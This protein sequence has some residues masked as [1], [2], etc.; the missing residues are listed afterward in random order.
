MRF[1]SSFGPRGSPGRGRVTSVTTLC[2]LGLG[3]L[4]FPLVGLVAAAWGT[5]A[6]FALCGALC[7]LAAATGLSPVLRGVGL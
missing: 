2:A 6:F 5:G 1:S 3:P 7:L 4:L